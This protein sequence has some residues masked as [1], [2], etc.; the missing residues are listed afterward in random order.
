MKTLLIL[1][2]LTLSLSYSNYLSAQADSAKL[3]RTERQIER[4]KK[5]VDKMN[6]KIARKERK[7]KR[8][9][10]KTRKRERR[11]DKQLK[12]IHKQERELEKMKKDSTNKMQPQLNSGTCV[13]YNKVPDINKYAIEK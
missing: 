1:I 7:I 8:Q 5:E 10:R 13:C 4:N 2:F 6:K 11:R 12:R 3:A 9:E